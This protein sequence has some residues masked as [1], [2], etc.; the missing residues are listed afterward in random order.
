MSSPLYWV[1]ANRLADGFPDTVEAL[2]EPDGLLAAGGDLAPERL[3][4]A[5]RSGI[6]PWYSAGQPIL[7]WAPDPRSI[8]Y[9]HALKISRSLRKTLKREQFA[10]T[11]DQAFEAVIR[12]C[13]APRGDHTGTWITD[14]MIDAYGVLHRRGLA[15]SIECWAMDELVGGLYGIAIGRVFFG[16][17]MFSRMTDASKVA[18]VTLAAKLAHWDYELIDCQVHNPHLASLGAI[19]I[20]RDEFN[21]LLHKLCAAPPSPGAWGAG[22]PS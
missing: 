14:S 11:I 16:E 20:R 5:Y 9:P 19:T 15:H 8:V 18:M 13:A 12:A 2:A 17:S 10:V 1:Q 3:V 4:M 7:W 21:A 6:F 22:T